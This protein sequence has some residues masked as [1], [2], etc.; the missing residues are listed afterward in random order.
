MYR[1]PPNVVSEKINQRDISYGYSHDCEKLMNYE[2]L[3][4]VPDQ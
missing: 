1:I 3:L 2:N 4:Q